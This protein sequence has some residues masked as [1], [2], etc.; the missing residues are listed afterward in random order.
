MVKR[1]MRPG[2]TH[3][4]GDDLKASHP[5]YLRL[6]A[7]DPRHAGAAIRTDYR[8]W[9]A[10][11]EAFVR[12]HRGDVLIEGAPGSA[13]ELFASVGP[14]A[15][16]R[17]PVDLVILAV[18]EADSLLAT[19]L[20]YAR[21]LQIGGLA[22]F[23][24]RAGHDTCV[25][26]LAETVARAE[27]H[28]AISSITVIRRDGTA[29]LRQEHGSVGEASWALAAEQLRPY[30]DQ[31]AV[32]FLQLHQALRRALTQHRHELDQA[33]ALA[34]PLMPARMQP[35]RLARPSPSPRSLPVRRVAGY[36]CL[37]SFSRAA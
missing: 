28:P 26:G 9:F 4:I 22:R 17:Y 23:T 21:A 32:Q 1:A 16:D 25:N 37:S 6:L 30:A 10:Q 36:D 8:S 31:E 2:T 14:F 12:R 29:L 11:A 13:E 15:A 3:L 19:A 18:R 34:R 7:E 27:Q 33:L 35:P 24:S 5:D 20:R